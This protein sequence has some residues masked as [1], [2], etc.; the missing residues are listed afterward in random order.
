MTA[1]DFSA[2]VD[3]L[4]TV[5]GETILPFFR[6]TLGVENKDRKGGFDPVTAADRA[7]EAAMRT[8]I[9]RTFPAHGIIG[10]EFGSERGD[11]EF[12]WV[13]DP[14]DGTKSF[15][16]G[17]PAWGTLIGLTRHGEPVFGMMHQPFTRERFSGDGA[18]ARYRGPAG[19]RALTTRACASLEQA[20][21]Y[22]TSPRL[23]NA[24]DRR[25]FARI[26]E[27]VRLSRYG[28]DCYA[29][30]MLAAGHV[31][32]VVETELK[33]HD[34][35]AL[36]PIITGAGGVVTTWE[37]EPPQ[38]GGRLIAAGDRRLHDA[39]RELLSPGANDP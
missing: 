37:G 17:M 19:D 2:F 22:T 1:I 13:L 8:L 14:I 18:A 9:S 10:E 24:D 32:L 16:C 28:G 25:A 3:D 12:V 31:D 23:M 26:E 39:A 36:I 21:L 5:S 38:A 20:V 15:I 33:P 30:C 7:A 4:A 29:Y 27:K 34:V 6:T 11:A 35:A